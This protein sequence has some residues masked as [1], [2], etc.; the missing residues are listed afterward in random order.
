MPTFKFFKDGA[1]VHM[2]EGAAGVKAKIDEL[3]GPL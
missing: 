3:K 1:E 2:I